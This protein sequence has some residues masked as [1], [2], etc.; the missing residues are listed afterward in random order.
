[1]RKDYIIKSNN[2]FI[3][4]RKGRFNEKQKEAIL[5]YI[6]SL[7]TGEAVLNNKDEIDEFIENHGINEKYR[8]EIEKA[9]SEDKKVYYGHVCFEDEIADRQ[10]R[11]LYERLW[12]ILEENNPDNYTAIDIKL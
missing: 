6:D 7:I 11:S 12:E 2:S 1:M 10:I 8:N 4:A 5:D 3:I 9:I